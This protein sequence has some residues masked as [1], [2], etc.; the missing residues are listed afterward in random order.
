MIVVHLI[1]HSD[2]DGTNSNTKH[3]P[4]TIK[5][6]LYTPICRHPNLIGCSYSMHGDFPLCCRNQFRGWEQWST[7]SWAAWVPATDAFGCQL[8]YVH[9]SPLSRLGLLYIQESI[10]SISALGHAQIH[11]NLW[12]GGVGNSLSKFCMLDFCGCFSAKFQRQTSSP[13][14]N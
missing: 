7:W 5:L 13:F 8:Q 1:K 11:H 14:C 2:H 9:Y 4:S 6:S 12:G 3:S 10:K